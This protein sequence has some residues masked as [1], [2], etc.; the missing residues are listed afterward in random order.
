MGYVLRRVHCWR[1]SRPGKRLLTGQYSRPDLLAS[2]LEP[3]NFE[4][5]ELD[6]IPV[7]RFVSIALNPL[8]RDK[9]P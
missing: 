1:G 2:P 5:G 4:T 6:A 8:A 3:R 9:G 7:R